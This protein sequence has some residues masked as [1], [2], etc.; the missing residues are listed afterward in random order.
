MPT[1]RHTL[2]AAAGLTP[3]VAG[4]AKA[5]NAL[6]NKKRLVLSSITA[7]SDGLAP[8]ARWSGFSDRVMGG[9]SDGRFNRELVDGR[10]CLRMTGRVTRE[11][12]GGF[13]QMALDIG[14]RDRSGGAFDATGYE[15]VEL[16]VNGNDEDYSV[17]VRTSDCGWYD[18][19]YRATFRAT[20]DWQRLTF[21][22]RDFVPSGLSVR[23]NPTRLERIAVLGWMREFEADL[24]VAEVALVA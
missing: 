19:S 15:G 17:H 9:V 2:F 5:S 12:N 3:L 7:D 6:E 1:R 24:A 22:W 18:E 11:S 20:R 4:L 13:I 23:L 16:L 14:G 10:A 21:A 8:G